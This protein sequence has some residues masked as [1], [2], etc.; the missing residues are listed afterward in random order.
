MIVSIDFET[1]SRVDLKKSGVHPYAM[2]TSTDILCI[3]WAV[4]DGPVQCIKGAESSELHELAE[5]EDAVFSAFNAGF[6]QAIWL[7]IMCERYGYAPIPI[8]RWRCSAAKSLSMSLPRSLGEVADS[9]NLPMRKDQ[10]GKQI[11]LKMC[12]PVPKSRQHLHGEWHESKEDFKILMDYCRDDVDTERALVNRLGFL[13]DEEQKVWELDQH[14]NQRGV[15]LDTNLAEGLLELKTE[16][17]D[18]I[19][20]QCEV[21]YG[22]KPSQVAKIKDHMREY[23][24]EIPR[25]KR[26]KKDP[27]TGERK[28][29][30]TESLGSEQIKKLLISDIDPEVKHLLQ[31]RQ[32]FATTSLAKATA[33]LNQ[34]VNSIARGQFMYHGANTGRWSGMG[35]QLHNL[36][37]GEFDEDFVDEEM[38]LATD[39]VKLRN[40]DELTSTFPDLRP[41]IILKSCLRG[42]I[43]SRPKSNL[44]VIDFS[45][46]EARV[47]AWL[48][49]QQ[50]VLD[51][52]R[53]GKDLYK[54]TASQ[55][56][57]KEYDDVT[58]QERFIGK[59]ASLALGYQ[60]GAGAFISMAT[61]FG[62]LVDRDLADTVKSDW[63][64]RNENI[65][66]FWY[67]LERAA[68]RAVKFGKTTKVGPVKFG[69]RDGFLLC[70]L[71]SGRCLAYYQPDVSTK[72]TDWGTKAQLTYMGSDQQRGIRWGRI[73][74]YGGKLAENVTQAVSR[75]LLAYSMLNI[76]D[77]YQIVGHVHDEVLVE[78]PET[79][80][81]ETITNMM[82]S[83]PAWAAGLPVDAD[84]FISD[85]YRK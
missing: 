26:W 84:G 32:D 16:I 61:N 58:K 70:K 38:A 21:E 53:D 31:M 34:S 81:L 40:L 52:F 51:S 78:V 36:P 72:D 45:Q 79:C 7:N 3:A 48:A 59:T 62:V 30:D 50:D 67:D 5:N 56:Y 68:I 39:L 57:E 44:C 6:E 64:A 28:Q 65:V 41:M 12:K 42:L 82:L 35:I 2:S 80:K 85:R 23:G 55:I 18:R 83:T 9:L 33:G 1:R 54:F 20:G 75:D 73:S 4:D 15:Q 24:V 13:S 71:P 74:T 49:G 10:E 25:V 22:F 37:R 14:I 27:E 77:R 69:V 17:C 66:R 11:M 19:S 43:V 47:L 29:M 63:R 8:S 60:G 76:A 46:I